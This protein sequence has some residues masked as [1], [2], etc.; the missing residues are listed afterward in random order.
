MERMIVVLLAGLLL[1]CSYQLHAS[2]SGVDD[3]RR[4]SYRHLPQSAI[5]VKLNG[6]HFW[7][8]NG[9]Y[10]RHSGDRYVAVRFPAGSRIP[11]LPSGSTRVVI[12]G[13]DY[14]RHGGVFYRW[15]PRLRAYQVVNLKPEHDNRVRRKVLQHGWVGK[16]RG[17]V[18]LQS[19]QGHEWNN[20]VSRIRVGKTTL[21]PITYPGRARDRHRSSDYR[22]SYS[23]D[24]RCFAPSKDAA[25]TCRHWH[26]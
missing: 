23:S 18:Y 8:V 21:T 12:Q 14:Y 11:A 5:A 22:R 16:E 6:I 2:P 26:K 10:Y 19:E 20:G 7:L 4:Q 15:L 25:V 17:P 13:E 3:S 1:L 9:F 24:V